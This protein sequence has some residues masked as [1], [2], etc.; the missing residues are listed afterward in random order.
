M[1]EKRGYFPLNDVT[2]FIANGGE[3]N[4]NYA[5]MPEV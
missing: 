5:E 4:P 1:V 3:G 2:I